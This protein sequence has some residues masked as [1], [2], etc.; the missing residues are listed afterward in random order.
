MEA[1]PKFFYQRRGGEGGNKKAH[2]NTATRQGNQI[3]KKWPEG[4]R[5]D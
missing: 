2:H 5:E 4:N 1:K 3:A